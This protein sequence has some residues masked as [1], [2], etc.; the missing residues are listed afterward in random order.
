MDTQ[1]QAGRVKEAG[2]T[3]QT[4]PEQVQPN[5]MMKEPIR[6]LCGSPERM[7]D[8]S[9]LQHDVWLHSQSTQPQWMQPKRPKEGPASD[10]LQEKTCRNSKRG[11]TNATCSE[12]ATD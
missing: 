4:S 10:Y 6:L 5:I 2:Q 9:Q 7:P 11:F 3:L 1:Q 8:G 12:A